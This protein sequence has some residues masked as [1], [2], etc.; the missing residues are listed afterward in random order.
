MKLFSKI[1]IQKVI[2][3]I[4]FFFLMISTLP[5]LSETF[6]NQLNLAKKVGFQTENFSHKTESFIVTNPNLQMIFPVT[7]S[8]KS[9]YYSV[10]LYINGEKIYLSYGIK[11]V[12]K[13]NSVELEANFPFAGNYELSIIF[14]TVKGGY[15]SINYKVNVPQTMA[16]DQIPEI[17][18]NNF[19]V[20]PTGYFYING[21]KMV[22]FDK[23]YFF[24]TVEKSWTINYK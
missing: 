23:P 17:T 8:V 15:A 6:E 14:Y 12:Y 21:L 1:S 22:N 2:Q 3:R 7:T 18:Q 10:L 5:I 9:G 16:A 19:P 4:I 20:F 24:N 13:S 11:A